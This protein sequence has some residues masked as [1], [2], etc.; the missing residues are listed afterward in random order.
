MIS[1][2][3]IILGVLCLFIFIAPLPGIVFNAGSALGIALGCA[4]ILYGIFRKRL[5]PKIHRLAHILTALAL[6]GL[7]VLGGLQWYGTGQQPEDG[8]PVTM[9]VLGCRV[10]GS[11]P[12]LMLWNRINAAQRYL[13]AHPEVKAI[14]S[15]GKGSDEN[16]SEGRCIY[17]KLLQAGIG[18]ERLYIEEES[19]STKENI[20][21]SEALIKEEGLEK[22]VLLVTNDYH[23]YRALRIAE[24]AGLSAYAWPARTALYLLPTYVLR[25][26]CGILYMWVFG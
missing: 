17:N 10:N 22:D 1:A 23:C 8:A 12:S 14:C 16:I 11:E 2:V 7:L 21:F 19:A 6:A 15:G 18:P 9:I 24:K 26:C 4:L 13:E 25:E 3:F 5:G 20:A